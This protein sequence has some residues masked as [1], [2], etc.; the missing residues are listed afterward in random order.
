L[1]ASDSD[2]Y[3]TSAS[4]ALVDA[5]IDAFADRGTRFLSL[6]AG[7][8]STPSSDDGLSRFKRRFATGTR[9]T[10]LCGR[11][12][13]RSDYDRLSRAVTLHSTEYFPEYRRGE[14]A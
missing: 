5:A 2:G 7:A 3:A 9:T 11:I 4:L 10:Y 13:R 14:F 1:A 6:G 8:G 12:F